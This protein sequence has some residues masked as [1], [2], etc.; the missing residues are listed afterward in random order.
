[1]L[2]SGTPPAPLQGGRGI[3]FDFFLE[4]NDSRHQP[5]VPHLVNLA[6][7]VFDI[8]VDKVR[9]PSLLEQVIANRKTL[10]SAV[11]NILGL[12]VE[13]QLATFDLVQRPNAG[14]HGQF[15]QF[16]GKHGIEVPAFRAGVE[17]VNEGRT[18]DRQRL[19]NIVHR[20]QRVRGRDGS[21]ILHCWMAS[22]YQR[23]HVLFPAVI[24]DALH[25]SRRA[26]RGVD[27]IRRCP[28]N[29]DIGIGIRLVV[30]HQ[31]QEVVVGMAHGGRNSA[32]AHVRTAAIAAEGDDVDGLVLHEALA[33]LDAECRGRSQCAGARTAQLGVHPGDAPGGS[34]VRG[35]SHVHAAS[36]PQNDRSGSRGLRHQFHDLRRL[37][38]LAGAV[39]GRVVLL[40]WNLLDSFEGFQ[41]LRR[42]F[43]YKSAHGCYPFRLWKRVETR[44]PRS[45]IHC[46]RGCALPLAASKVISVIFS[47]S[48][49]VTSRPP[50]PQMKSST[51]GRLAALL[52]MAERTSVATTPLRS[53]EPNEK[54]RSITP[55]ALKRSRH[56]AISG[57][58]KGRNQRSRTNPTFLPSSRSFRTA[59]LTGVDIVPMP[60]STTSASSV[61]YS[62]KNG[63][64]Y[65]RPNVFS[66]SV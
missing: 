44:Y 23:R 31:D 62:S 51:G 9:E 40:V 64:P 65:L 15:A 19:A 63:L 25:F 3:G 55:T 59:T 38:A 10:E 43:V 6:L 22:H 49:T 56:F 57:P 36:A 33:H 48:G 27:A 29:L 4:R 26:E 53:G 41:V 39:A 17:A 24:H 11:R 28:G 1:M 5:L 21:Y 47:T 30:I 14:V 12:A 50:S 18:A 60:S 45:P 46:V 54:S 37:A 61:I 35:V 34:I 20:L 66:K 42:F 13:R 7:E 52:Y 58:A 16:E 8:F 2:K 32:Q